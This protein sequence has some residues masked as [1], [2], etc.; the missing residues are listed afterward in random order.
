MT[1][2]SLTTPHYVRCIKPNPLNRCDNFDSSLV[3]TQLKCCGVIEAVRVS[4]AGFPNRFR[5]SEFME[6]YL[7]IIKHH[8]YMDYR[9]YNRV[10][11][12]IKTT[13]KMFI[14]EHKPFLDRV[15]GK[16]NER[17]RALEI[18]KAL[19]QLVVENPTFRRNS[20][21]GNSGSAVSMTNNDIMV[22]AGVQMGLS[23]V[24]MRRN[25]FD[26]LEQLRMS[27]IRYNV[28]VVQKYF[29][30]CRA[31]RY[32][33]RLKKS[34]LS[35]QCYT[36]VNIAKRM[37]KYL[38]DTKAAIF[39]QKIARGYIAR[40]YRKRAISYII[41]LQTRTRMMFARVV[42]KILYTNNAVTRI[43]KYYRR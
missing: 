38:R 15:S 36:R 26:I 28:I 30:C 19:A 41:R 11:S 33:K 27:L 1:N 14:K 24:F 22:E 5:M 16:S 2:V 9:Q 34:T 40:M 21:N 20:N 31:H 13:Y 42:L 43:S 35:M 7:C 8:N 39:L 12:T 18:C 6:R 25:C 10:N 37:L 17:E 23:L 4:R 3:S 32:Y 29:R